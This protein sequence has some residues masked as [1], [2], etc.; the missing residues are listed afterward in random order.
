MYFFTPIYH[1]FCLSNIFNALKLKPSVKRNIFLI[2]L[3]FNFLSLWFSPQVNADNASSDSIE[4]TNTIDTTSQ[5]YIPVTGDDNRSFNTIISV[6]RVVQAPAEIPDSLSDT[7]VQPSDTIVIQNAKQNKVFTYT[8]HGSNFEL[9]E[10]NDPENDSEPKIRFK[11]NPE[12]IGLGYFIPG[13]IFTFVGIGL[14]DYN[15]RWPI[16]SSGFFAGGA[17]FIWHGI[18]C[19]RKHHKWGNRFERNSFR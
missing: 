1:I 13:G 2:T 6:K 12:S 18:K 19:V 9:S 14:V 5:S 11:D 15:K 17:L 8:Y 10:N 7:S 16:Y 3:L 4:Y